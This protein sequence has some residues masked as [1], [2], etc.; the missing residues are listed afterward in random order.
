LKKTK[1]VE[2]KILPIGF[3]TKNSAVKFCDLHFK[4]KLNRSE[5]ESDCI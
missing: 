3:G 4:G 1:V 5:G 2:F